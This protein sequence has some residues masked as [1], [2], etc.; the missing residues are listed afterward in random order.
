M[1]KKRLDLRIE[2]ALRDGIDLEAK[3]TGKPLTAIV[4][5]YIRDGLA[6]DHGQLVELNSLPEIRAA[7]RQET[8]Q[9][10]GQLYQQLSL[11]LAKAV[12]GVTTGWRSYRPM[13]CATVASP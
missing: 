2:G 6:R 8:E 10:M 1:V 3:R 12:V 11:D 7:V 13:E 9:A 5:G 4:E